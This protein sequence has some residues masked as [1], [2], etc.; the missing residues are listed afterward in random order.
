MNIKLF[1]K[2]AKC[3]DWAEYDI[4]AFTFP[5]GERHVVLGDSLLAL[6][7]NTSDMDDLSFNILADIKSSDDLMDVLL[8]N[9]ALKHYHDFDIGLK[10]PYFPYAQQDRYAG[11]GAAFSLKVF[12]GII[13]AANFSSVKI[14]EP[15]SDVTPALLNNCYIEYMDEYVLEFIKRLNFEAGSVVLVAPDGGAVKRTDRIFN[16]LSANKCEALDK[17]GYAI[18]SKTRD[19]NT[20]KLRFLGIQGDIVKKNLLILDDI[21]IGGGTFLQLA[22]GIKNTNILIKSLSLFTAHGIYSNG[23]DEL[24]KYYTNIGCVNNRSVHKL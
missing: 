24:R 7:K 3:F 13:N 23:L 21:N 17:S 12:V 8:L 14:L 16:F 11:E 6:L 10:L 2:K 19:L 15:H 22:E 18:A 20:G 9:N 4:K 1:V 5:G